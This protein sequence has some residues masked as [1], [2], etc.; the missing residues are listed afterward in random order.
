[1]LVDFIK[2]HP[3]FGKKVLGVLKGQLLVDGAHFVKG[4][5]ITVPYHLA[6]GLIRGRDG[7]NSMPYKNA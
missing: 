4:R 6:D 1:M 2:L 7:G 5:P 3:G